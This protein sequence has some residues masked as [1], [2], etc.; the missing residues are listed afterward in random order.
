MT[1]RLSR[2]C[3]HPIKA[4]GREDLASVLLSAGECLPGD[5]RWAVAHEAAKLVEGWNPCNNFHRGAKAPQLMAIEAT[6]DGDRVTLRHPDRPDLTFAPDDP[7]DLPAFVAWV[8]PLSPPDRTQPKRIVT[9]GRGMTD[10]AFPSVSILSFATLAALSE[11]MGRPLSGDRFRGNLW[12]SGCAPFAEFDWIGRDL[13]V[14]NAVV[15]IKERITRCRATMANPETGLV[16]ADTLSALKAAYG[17]QDFGV[18]AEVIEGGPI[19]LQDK[20]ILL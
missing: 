20:G 10:S 1:L 6:L 12:L 14:G 17:H 9:A 19:A 18:Y 16:D 7:D 4:H 13:Q 5:R 15:R 8:T 11:R 2:I 3:R